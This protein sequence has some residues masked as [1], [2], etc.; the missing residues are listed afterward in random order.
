MGSEVIKGTFS[1]GSLKKTNPLNSVAEA[2]GIPV[3][4]NIRICKREAEVAS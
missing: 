1:H 4:V 2:L 3:S